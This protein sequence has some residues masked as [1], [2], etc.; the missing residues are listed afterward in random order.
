MTQVSAPSE[1]TPRRGHDRA[2]PSATAAE[3]TAFRAEVRAWL[4]SVAARRPDEAF[5]WGEGDFSVA[6]FDD[7]TQEEEAAAVAAGRAWEQRKFDAG[8]G[9]VHWPVELGGKGLPHRFAS[10]VRQEET[11]FELPRRNELFSV[12]QSLIA[13]TI[14][15]WG[16]PEQKERFLRAL[17]RTDVLACQLFSEP[18]AGSD[19]ASVSTRAVRDGDDWVISGQKVWSSGAQS[20]QWGEAI[21]RSLPDVGKHAGLTAFLVPMDASGV[22][23]RPIRQMSGGASFNEVFLDEVRVPDALRLGPEGAGWKV[24]LT[25]LA[26]ERLDSGSLGGGTLKKATALTRHLGRADEPFVRDRLADLWI[27]SRVQSMTSQRIAAQLASGHEAGPEGSIGKLA[28]TANMRRTSDLV[29]VM[30]GCRLTAD[31]G[32]WGTYA[33]NDQVLGAPGYRIAGGSDEIQRNIIGERVLGLA[34][35]LEPGRRDGP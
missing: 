33:W 7:W 3:P 1:E 27:S 16:T 32:E 23:V 31:S 25:T 17:L 35:G 34:R 5:T 29:S 13:P 21:C 11:G 22:T 18:G 10:I 4:E 20:A 28:A 12:T 14:A 15:T 30:L 6:V 2:C 26:A 9:A 8:W 24:A 19:L